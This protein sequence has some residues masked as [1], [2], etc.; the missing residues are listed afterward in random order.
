MSI[1]VSC[2]LY[3]LEDRPVNENKYIPIFV[4]WLAYSLKY[5]KFNSQDAL[6]ITIDKDTLDFLEKDSLY[7][8]ILSNI[9]SQ[10]E[11]IIIPRPKTH[12]QGM[13][14]KYIYKEYTQKYFMYCDIDVLIQKT[15]SLLISSIPENT[16][17]VHVEGTLADT[18]YNKLFPE[19]WIRDHGAKHLGFSAGKFI[20][21]GSSLCKE[22][23]E[24][25]NKF[26]LQE[27]IETFYTVEQ[28]IF[29]YAIYSIP[30][31]KYNVDMNTIK[32]PIICTNNNGYQ[33]DKA[34]LMDLMG[35]PGN[36]PAHFEKIFG[37]LIEYFLTH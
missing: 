7:M 24:L 25:I 35:E 12:A 16:L 3:T 4:N 13:M 21:H 33:K 1:L 37:L 30:R 27:P 29:N 11:F 31:D 22:L 10:K 6:R 19:D 18:N 20:I 23:F 9:P 14:A 34:I 36:G 2:I 17:A 8:A 28:P 32:Y 26:A 5:A 15:L